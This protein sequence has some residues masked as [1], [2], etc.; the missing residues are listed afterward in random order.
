MLRQHSKLVRACGSHD[1]AFDPG[2]VGFSYHYDAV[3]P[4][5]TLLTE[6]EKGSTCAAFGHGFVDPLRH[7]CST[8]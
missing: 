5:R 7:G 6:V 2:D 1:V 3:V 4:M 8:Y